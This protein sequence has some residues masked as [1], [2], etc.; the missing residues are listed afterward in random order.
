MR[1]IA[2]TLLLIR[3][4]DVFGWLMDTVE[5]SNICIPQGPVPS[6]K[7]TVFPPILLISIVLNFRKNWEQF[8]YNWCQIVLNA[9]N[10]LTN[11][12]D[13][14]EMAQQSSVALGNQ[15]DT[16]FNHLKSVWVRAR[17]LHT[18]SILANFQFASLYLAYLIK[19]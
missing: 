12:P 15:E 7:I 19:V 6:L 3:L 4:V 16:P 5:L 1:Y 17:K 13:I 2:K 14:P 11:D 9:S 10:S 8:Q 18:N